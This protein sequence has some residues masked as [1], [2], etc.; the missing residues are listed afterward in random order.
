MQPPG[1]KPWLLFGLLG[2]SLATNLVMAI[3]WPSCEQDCVPLAAPELDAGAPEIEPDPAAGAGMVPPAMEQEPVAAPVDMAGYQ[4]I[5]GVVE[6]NLART[7]QDLGIDS[8]DAVNAVFARQFAWDLDLRRDLQKGDTITAVY[9]IDDNGD[10]DM[11][12]AWFD[13]RKLGKALKAYRFQVPGDDNPSYWYPDGGEVPYRLVNGPIQQY[14]Q[15]T[16]LID[17]RRGHDGWDFKAAEGT[18]IVSPKAGRVE[19]TNWNHTVN[20]NCVEV[21]QSDG[22][23]ALYLHLSRNDVQPGDSVTA[24]QLIGAVGNTGRSTNAHL[25]YQLEKAGKVLDPGEYHGTTR[26]SLPPEA[27]PAFEQ[28]MVRLDA[29]VEAG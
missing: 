10:I 16:S 5:H 9:H 14:I 18:P 13:S 8:A 22:V 12:L 21:V 4:V 15:I 28:E 19:R 1:G 29:M 7:F 17:D 20:G 24:G 27:M 3:W 23:H 6:A 11:P 2:A 26:R 25:H